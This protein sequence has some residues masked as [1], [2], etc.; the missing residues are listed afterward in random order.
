MN[1]CQ[2]CAKIFCRNR[3]D[4]KDFCE[5]RITFLQAGVTEPPKRIELEEE[6]KEKNVNE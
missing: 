3:L 6:R 4:N 1:Y 2:L 5:E